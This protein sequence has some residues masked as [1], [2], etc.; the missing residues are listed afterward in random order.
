MSEVGVYINLSGG[1]LTYTGKACT[2]LGAETKACIGGSLSNEN[3]GKTS[4]TG[5]ELFGSLEMGST[6]LTI[7]DEQQVIDFANPKDEYGIM[8]T[9]SGNTYIVYGEGNG[10]ASFFKCS[11]LPKDEGGKYKFEVTE[12][13]KS[14]VVSNAK[15][16][17]Q[18]CQKSA[19]RQ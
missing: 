8:K 14:L 1:S 9:Q 15:G 6:K 11:E 12:N 19:T 2:K 18:T 13:G 10:K 7:S 4:I 16:A 3:E 17:K 5:R